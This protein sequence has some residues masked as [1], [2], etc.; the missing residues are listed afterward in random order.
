M[1]II[2]QIISG[3]CIILLN[4]SPVLM[5][6]E[7]ENKKVLIT[8]KHKFRTKQI[9]LKDKI[10]LPKGEITTFDYHYLD[11]TR[12]TW[13]TKTIENP[14]LIKKLIKRLEKGSI[15]TNIKVE[16]D[17]V[18]LSIGY[19]N[20][21]NCK[22]MSAENTALF[23]DYDHWLSLTNLKGFVLKLQRIARW[24]SFD[25][26]EIK[27]IQSID[28]RYKKNTKA[29]TNK[30]R[31]NGIARCLAFAKPIGYA[32]GCPFYHTRLYLHSKNKTYY[33]A[34]AN[35]ACPV[36]IINNTYFELDNKLH[37]D[38]VKLMKLY[39]GFKVGP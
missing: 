6:Q 17:G 10:I 27:D 5:A 4:I 13:K 8:L 14:K 26:E 9:Q 28:L 22:I 32:T 36:I 33:A 7:E 19:K 3:F 12:Y 1:K 21:Y 38:L 11:T 24:K 18:T 35:D 23:Y 39:V 31:V 2:I 25:I 20:G 29:L 37:K 30:S 16:P 15:D 34:L